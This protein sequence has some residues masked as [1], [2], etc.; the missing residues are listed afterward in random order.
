MERNDKKHTQEQSHTVTIKPM[1][2]SEV[3]ILVK[4]APWV[5]AADDVERRPSAGQNKERADN[6]SSVTLAGNSESSASR[7]SVQVF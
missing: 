5:T 6:Y 7:A 1:L 3:F 4:N 2:R